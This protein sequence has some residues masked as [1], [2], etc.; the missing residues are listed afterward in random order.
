MRRIPPNSTPVRDV[1]DDDDRVTSLAARVSSRSGLGKRKSR[2]ARECRVEFAVAY[3]GER[4][5][6]LRGDRTRRNGVR[7]PDAF[8]QASIRVRRCF[9]R[10]ASSSKLILK[11]GR[12]SFELSVTF[13]SLLEK[14]R[15]GENGK[16]ESVVVP[17]S[18][19]AA[20]KW[21]RKGISKCRE[22]GQ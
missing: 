13:A 6:D 9:A 7:N 16:S 11:V 12:L 1:D 18:S 5:F 19:I 2:H 20:R 3:L 22:Q 17:D 8:T 14:E 10:S 4:L 15:K 21:E